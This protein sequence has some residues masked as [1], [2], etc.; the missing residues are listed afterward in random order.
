[1]ISESDEAA[2]PSPAP[3]ATLHR[4]A[5]QDGRGHEAHHSP[6]APEADD[7]PCPDGRDDSRNPD[8]S[9]CPDAP[10]SPDGTARPACRLQ[11]ASAPGDCHCHEPRL[12]CRKA[13]DRLGRIALPDAG[14]C[15][16]TGCPACRKA[17]WPV[18]AAPEHCCPCVPAACGVHHRPAA[19]WICRCSV[20][21][22][23]SYLRNRCRVA[24]MSS[25]KVCGQLPWSCCRPLPTGR[26]PAAKAVKELPPQLLRDRSIC[27]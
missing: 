23:K 18:P 16:A 5:H 8:G 20:E 14:R 2:E 15:P 12:V 25:P 4:G 1:M 3:D 27:S 26:R 13:A 19:H 11:D 7:C 22:Y 9:G 21:P 24:E 10:D 6:G 17:A